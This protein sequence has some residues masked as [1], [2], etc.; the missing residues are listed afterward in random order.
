MRAMRQTV[1]VVGGGLGGLAAAGELQR[2]GFEVTL[3]EA[4]ELGGK[5]G[6][7]CSGSVTLDT[8]P[9][10][11]TMPDVVRTA[12]ARLDA[13][14]LLPAFFE[15]DPQCHYS[16]ASGAQLTVH[17]DVERTA[18]SVAAA[19][20]PSEALGVHSFY[21]EAAALYRFA[22]EPY[23]ESPFDGLANFLGRTLR[24]GPAAMLRGLAMGT[25]HQLAARHFK[26]P[27]LQQFVGRFAT[28][29]GASPYQA[30]EVFALIAQVERA[31]GTHH[32]QGGIGALTQALV[33]AL[34]RL[35]VSFALGAKANWSRNGSRYRVGAA[36]DQRDF[37]AVVVNADPLESLGRS[38][39]PLS[40]SGYVLLLEADRR[41]RLPHHSVLF[42]ADD[43]EEFS[44]LFSGRLPRDPTVYVCHPAATD[45]SMASEGRSGL[46]LMAN[47]P[48]LPREAAPDW[49]EQA[50]RLR[51]FMLT[52]LEARCP[53]VGEA[54]FT[55]LAQRTPVDFARMGA[56]GGSLYGFLPH[57]RLGPFRRPRLRGRTPGL[58]FAGGGT[59][60]G[61]GV[62]LVLLSGHFAAALTADY[63]RGKS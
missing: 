54:S 53:A 4:G 46:Y 7:Q 8:G 16:F 56:P 31:F 61:G 18:A 19:L 49:G 6:S 29:A 42:G 36:D 63:L 38:D 9:T 48:V 2:Q 39:E 58:F 28:Y 13:L 45:S 26:T 32:V 41:L 1:A 62:P 52:R 11:L 33:R 44:A 17:R 50:R 23:L 12:F 27:E 55:V 14:D 51:D 22:G 34:T 15:V 25:L 59:H 21:Q 10:L 20:G 60:P 47:A 57:G 43:A 30:S 5:A 24:Q 40:M 3:F 37:D 35:G